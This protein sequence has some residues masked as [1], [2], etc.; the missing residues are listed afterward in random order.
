MKDLV[1]E[2]AAYRS[3]ALVDGSPI[4]AKCCEH[5]I[6]YNLNLLLRPK[7]GEKI[8]PFIR[9]GMTMVPFLFEDDLWFMDEKKQDLD[10]LLGSEIDMLRVFNFHP[11]HL[12]LDT[13]HVS[14]Y[15]K[16]KPYYHLPDKMEAY[17]NRG[18][19]GAYAVFQELVGK[20]EDKGM[21]FGLISEIQEGM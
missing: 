18:R 5:G 19:N 11:V 9:T 8:Y 4:I 3:H 7:S 15:E 21:G 17:R 1:P 12:W 16:A 10:F 13:E 2:A 14:R 20:A 6:K